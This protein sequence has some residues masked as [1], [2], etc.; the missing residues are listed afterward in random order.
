VKIRF[1]V[2]RKALK[3][4]RKNADLS[5]LDRKQGAQAIREGGSFSGEIPETFKQSKTPS[6]SSG[7]KREATG[8]NQAK[9]R[10][11]R[12]REKIGEKNSP[13]IKKASLKKTQKGR[14]EGKRIHLAETADGHRASI[15][16]ANVWRTDA[17]YSGKDQLMGSSAEW[18]GSPRLKPD[19]GVVFLVR[20]S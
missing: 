8:C 9:A 17:G 12:A 4:A 20:D 13:K 7:Q 14:T 6:Y 2:T 1:K 5:A 16:R 15:S 18:N 10:S 3:Q 19:F 11:P